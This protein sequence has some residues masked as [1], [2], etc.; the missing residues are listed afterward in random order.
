MKFEITTSAVDSNAL[1]RQMLDHACGACVIFEGW[2]RNRNEGRV[3]Q[4]LEYEIYRPL[5]LSEGEKVVA[6]A[7]QKFDIEDAACMHREGLLE[8][9][10]TAVVALAAARHREEAFLACK[11][12]IDEVKTR[13]PIWKKEFYAD[14]EAQWVNCQRCSAHEPATALHLQDHKDG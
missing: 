5:A 13:L 12:I 2:I 6:E 8:L 10:E 11:Y 4:R 9:G 7:L 1:R 14:G 3:V